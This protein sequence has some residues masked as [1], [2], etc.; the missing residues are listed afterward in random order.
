MTF[1]VVWYL[2][3]L[4]DR[5]QDLSS[6]GKN[7]PCEAGGTGGAGPAGASFSTGQQWLCAVQR[8]LSV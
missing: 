8:L 6:E 1:P 3:L 2:R 4:G 5:L 7:P